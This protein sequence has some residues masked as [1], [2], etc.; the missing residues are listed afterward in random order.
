MLPSSLRAVIC[1]IVG[2]C[3]SPRPVG[4]ATSPVSV[5]KTSYA[6]FRSHHMNSTTDEGESNH[7]FDVSSELDLVDRRRPSATAAAA[8]VHRQKSSSRPPHKS[9]QSNISSVSSVDSWHASVVQTT[10]DRYRYSTV[11]GRSQLYSCLYCSRKITVFR[12]GLKPQHWVP[13]HAALISASLVIVH[14]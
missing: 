9:S 4:Q 10:P 13:A 5:E 12:T 1:D 8:R 14:S 6:M 7:A 11:R 2:C 3:N